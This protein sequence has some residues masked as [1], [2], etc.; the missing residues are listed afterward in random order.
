MMVVSLSLQERPAESGLRP[1][2]LRTDLVPLADLIETAFADTMDNS[3]RAAVREM[4]T[5]SRLGPG[6]SVLL[7]MNDL[8]QGV[9]LGFVWIEDGKLVGNTS[10]YPANVPTGPTWIIANVAVDPNYRGRGIARKLVEASLEMIQKRSRSR[11]AAAVLQVEADNEIAQHLYERLGFTAER[12]WTQWRRS[13]TVRMP[14]PF[15]DP[16][17]YI[18]RRRANEWRAEYAMAQQ[19]RAS[20]GMGWLRPLHP[21]LFRRPLVKWLGDLFSF[22]SLERLVIRGEADDLRAV[23]WVESAFAASTVQLTLMVNPAYQGVY[24]EALVN[25]L[26]RRYSLRSALTLEHPAEETIT[27]SV[28]QRYQFHAQRTLIHMRW[29]T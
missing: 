28:L 14:Q 11:Q 5:L 2:N 4:R 18:T 22:R 21:S 3:G 27:A 7:G 26:A 15:H 6:L 8:A 12:T 25:L 20:G 1:V 16:S 13:S 9:G 24:D 23:M 29:T 17:I 19:L 10:V